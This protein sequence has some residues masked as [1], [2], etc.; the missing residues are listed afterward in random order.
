M[1]TSCTEGRGVAY[2][3]CRVSGL[4]KHGCACDS[5]G[6]VAARRRVRK[7]GSLRNG[8]LAMCGSPGP[9]WSLPAAILAGAV[10]NHGVVE[11]RCVQEE[12]RSLTGIFVRGGMEC[13]Q[14]SIPL[15][16][17]LRRIRAPNGESGIGKT[18]VLMVRCRRLFV[19]WGIRKFMDRIPSVR[20]C[21]WTPRGPTGYNRSSSVETLV[22]LVLR[23]AG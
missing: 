23:W 7:S 12:A 19:P 15:E 10:P 6:E 11:C 17:C 20:R 21:F 3:S 16:P 2:G 14:K 8:R 5:K 13:M 18:A 22:F 1:F 4:S 9:R